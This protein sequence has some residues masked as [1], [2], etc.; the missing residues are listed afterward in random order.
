MSVILLFSAMPITANAAQNTWDPDHGVYDISTEADLLAFR[1]C[2]NLAKS[3]NS[4]YYF[5]EETVNLLQDISMTQTYVCP[6]SN[7]DAEAQ[8]CGT[9][10]GHNHTIS[11]ITMTPSDG[12]CTALLPFLGNATIKD[13]TLENVT[14]DSALTWTAPF[15][16]VSLGEDKII[17]CHVTG[18]STIMAGSSFSKD[19]NYTAGMIADNYMG[20]L[21]IENCTVGENVVI[22]GR[23]SSGKYRVAGGMLAYARNSTTTLVKNCVNRATISSDY[24]GSGIVGSFIAS[25]SVDNMNYGAIVDC[26]NYGDVYSNPETTGTINEYAGI[27]A[28]SSNYSSVVINRCGNYGDIT[29]STHS[30]CGSGGIAAEVRSAAIVNCFNAGNITAVSSC[31]LGGVVGHTRTNTYGSPIHGSVDE[32]DF[33]YPQQYNSIT[34][35]YNVGTVTTTDG[36]SNYGPTG[37]IVGICQE[38]DTQAGNSEVVNVY[39]FAEV[40]A[41]AARYGAVTADT[42][43]KFE[44]AFAAD[45]TKAITYL[46]DSYG[47][48]SPYTC[49]AGYYSSPSKGGTVYPATVVSGETV[50]SG[51]DDAAETISDTPLSTDLKETLD[52]FV[53]EVNPDFE[54]QS[55]QTFTLLPW[56]YSDGSDGLNIHPVFGYDIINEA[57]ESEKDTNGGYL[58]TSKQGYE[59]CKYNADSDKTI[60]VTAHNNSGKVLKSLTVTDQYGDAVAVTNAGNGVYTFDM[61]EC[62]V[63]VDAVWESGEPRNTVYLTTKDSVDINFIIDADYYTSDENAYVMLNY[64]HNPRT[65]ENDFKDENVAL[66]R[67]EKTADGRYKFTIESAPAQLTEPIKITLYDSN[68]TELYDVD[69][70]MWQ[71]CKDIINQNITIQQNTSSSMY[72][73]ETAEEWEKASELCKS[74][75]DYATAAQVYFEYNTSDMSSKEVKDEDEYY[76]DDATNEDYYHNVTSV[77]MNDVKT[78]GHAVASINGSFPVA[79]TSLMSLSNTEVRFYYEEELDPENYELSVSCSEWFGSARPTAKFDE[80]VSGK[81]ISVGG[82]ESVNL[83]EPFVLTIRDKTTNEVTTITYNAMA[84]CFTVLRDTASS[85]DQKENELRTLVKS[86]YRYNQYAREYFEAVNS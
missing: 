8:F 78:N 4:D 40:S 11:N 36:D 66:S 56:T 23:G 38:S 54:Q 33:Y 6:D 46:H 77:T 7:G 27:L 30:A 79:H 62:D 5:E 63:T 58:T 15:A 44:N 42:D 12:F 43:I 65:Y 25:G 34:N 52:A 48:A 80:A 70:S 21:T 41:N 2:L 17:N 24:I 22:N 20:S 83:N 37:G 35:C 26:Y 61:P 64:N 82:I 76:H 49:T 68:G 3:T 51:V 13:L 57:P 60:T 73:A 72:D 53:D 29:V 9:F 59:Y 85:S 67:V 81:F 50:G 84:Y 86:V 32:G 39:N 16:P 45:G 71:Y 75:M 18:N 10:D 69:Y 31:N 28:E 1:D 47:H 74:L 14:I 55:G 19:W